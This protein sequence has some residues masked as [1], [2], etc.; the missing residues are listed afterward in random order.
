MTVRRAFALLRAQGR[1]PLNLHK[2]AAH[3]PALLTPLLDLIHAAR[4]QCRTSRRLRELVIVRTA[5]LQASEYELAHHLPMARA[6]G[7]DDAELA[8]VDSWRDGEYFDARERAALAYA[9]HVSGDAA[10]DDVALDR[11]FSADEIVELTMVAACY[12][13]IARMIRAWDV[14]LE[15]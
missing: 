12:V 6:A 1:E 3:A 2:T 15:E 14:Q 11:H 7:V 9:E 13:M 5:Q 10:R 8:V 4:H